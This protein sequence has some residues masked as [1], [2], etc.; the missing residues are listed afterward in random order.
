MTDG[1]SS[2]PEQETRTSG[3]A[4]STRPAPP[5]L[6]RWGPF[7]LLT[8]VGRGSFRRGLPGLQSDPP[9]SCR[10]QAAAA[11]RAQSRSKSSMPCSGRPGP[12]RGSATRTSRRSTASIVMR[13]AS[14]SGATSSR[15]TRS[16]R[17]SPPTVRWGPAKRRSDRHRRLPGRRGGAR[18]RIPA[19][20]HQGRQ[21]HARRGRPDSADGLRPDAGARDQSRDVRHA[22]L[23]GSRAPAR[24]TRSRHERYLRHR[25]HALPP[26]DAAVSD[27]RARRRAFSRGARVRQAP[28]A[29]QRQARF[30]RAARPRRGDGDQ[31]GSRAAVLE[32]RP[33]DCRA[34]AGGRSPPTGGARP[35]RPRRGRSAWQVAGAAACAAALL[36][37]P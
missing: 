34:V 19:P 37:L 7:E 15:A 36:G 9:A 1:Q 5:T 26:A 2:D 21:R 4:A 22:G 18:R 14:D 12:S 27:R 8:C 16:R 23:H 28:D 29:A 6:S 31:P 24:R 17:S 25:R 20:R 10:A 35:V 11:Q 33:D 32:H 13:A 30:A 3:E